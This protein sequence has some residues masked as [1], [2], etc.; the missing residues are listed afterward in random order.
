MR[1]WAWKDLLKWNAGERNESLIQCVTHSRSQDKG[2]SCTDRAAPPSALQLDP[3]LNV[4]PNVN[5]IPSEETVTLGDSLH[6]FFISLCSFFFCNFEYV[7]YYLISS[8][9]DNKFYQPYNAYT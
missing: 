2:L 4:R 8:A 3:A 7:S 5:R 1:P 6:T 9:H